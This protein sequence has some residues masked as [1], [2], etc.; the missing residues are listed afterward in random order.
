LKGNVASK[1][2]IFWRAA[3]NGLLILLQ[4][5][6]SP[7]GVFASHHRRAPE[8]HFLLGHGILMMAHRRIVLTG[9]FRKIAPPR[10]V[11]EI[12]RDGAT[13]GAIEAAAS[14]KTKCDCDSGGLRAR[15]LKAQDDREKLPRVLL[16]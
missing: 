7:M 14:I 13:S 8:R 11:V 16:R 2:A 12:D 9:H 15:P 4:L 6:L 3:F 10:S 1:K 5:P